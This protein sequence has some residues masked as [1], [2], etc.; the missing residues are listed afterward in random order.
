MLYA[1]ICTDKPHSLETRLANRDEHRAY[2]A[3]LG[4]RLIFGGPFSDDNGNPDGS[5]IVIEANN[6]DEA[7]AV[8]QEDPFS[9]V[10]LFETVEIRPFTWTAKNP[11]NG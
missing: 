5:L 11:A 7:L 6:R 2:L 1:L 3:S 10:G 4:D 8:S 9:R